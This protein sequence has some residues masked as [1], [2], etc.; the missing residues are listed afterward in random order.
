M[1][2]PPLAAVDKTVLVGF[3]LAKLCSQLLV[4]RRYGYH[5]D[6]LYFIEC[7]KHLALGY[8]DQMPLVPWLTRLVGEIAGY[9]LLALRFLPALASAASVGIAIL[10]VGEWGGKR[11][12]QIVAALAMFIAPAYLQMASLM[13]IPVFECL[14]WSLNAY[15]LVRI[16]KGGDSR[17]WLA[18]GVVSGFGL[19]NKPTML[20]WGAGMAFGLALTEHRRMLRSPWP[21]LAAL[22]AFAIFSPN[23]I[24][25]QQNGWATWEFLRALENGVLAAIPRHLFLLGQLLYMHPLSIPIAVAGLVWLFSPAGQRF[26][27]F[28]WLYL[29][30]LV[31]LTLG[32]GKPYYLAAAYPPLFAAGAVLIEDRFIRQVRTR[33]LA[34]AGGLATG[35]VL[36]GLFALPILDIRTADEV[37]RR[38]LGFVVPDPTMITGDFHREYGWREQAEAVGRA[39]RSLSDSE[40]ARSVVLAHDYS[41]AAAIDFFGKE[42]GLPHASSGHMNYFLWGPPEVSDA[43]VLA[44]G[45]PQQVLAEFCSNV[46]QVDES[47]HPLAIASENHLPV[48]RCKHAGPWTTDEW[49]RLKRYYH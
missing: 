5:A 14:F 41:E 25:Q 23:I 40:R 32:R 20:L 46:T 4:A 10:L 27:F 12:A 2:Q 42:W 19:L 17:L 1:R 15:L 47:F 44:I 18:V 22:I 3:V 43:T 48:Y 13:H 35:G 29:F 49:Q 7:A 45:M 37:I 30:C 28:A 9:D 6:E 39:Y 24:W 11:A 38:L 8:V 33:L 26:R 16:V 36:T 31:L 21:W 34:I